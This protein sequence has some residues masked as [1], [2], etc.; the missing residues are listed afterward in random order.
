MDMV[1]VR[2]RDDMAEIIVTYRGCGWEFDAIRAGP[3]QRLCP[4]CPPPSPPLSGTTISEQRSRPL[5]AGKRPLCARCLRI[6]A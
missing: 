5:R 1:S 6:A 3:R 4:R 2:R